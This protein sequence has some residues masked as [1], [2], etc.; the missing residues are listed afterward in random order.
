MNPMNEH[1]QIN[2]VE[3]PAR[4]LPQTKAFFT[5][6]FGWVFQ[7][8][9]PEYAAFSSK[10]LDGGFYRADLASSADNGGALI[11][12]YSQDLEA[13]QAKVEHAGGVIVK[14]IFSF[15]GGRRF[16]FTEPSGNELAV[17]SDR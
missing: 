12:L 10:G 5:A 6:A 15:P 16:H 8:Y 13:T 1:E 11:V 17:W 14:P 7:D 3:F 2:Y 4:D 9:G